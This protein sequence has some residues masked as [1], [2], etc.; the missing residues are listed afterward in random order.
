MKKSEIK[1]VI[2]DIGGVLLLGDKKMKYGHQNINVHAYLSKQFNMSLKEWF[3][4]IQIDY[5]KSIT[6]RIS[7]DN[8]LKKIS[9]QLNTNPKKLEKLLILAHK[10]FYKKNKELYDSAK[11]L[12]RKCLI[13]ILSDQTPFS[14]KA[15]LNKKFLS[16]FN[17]IILSCDV[18]MRKPDKEIYFLL[19]KRINKIEKVSFS[20]ILFIDNRQFNLEPAKKLG[21]QTLLFKSN[22]QL[23]KTSIWRNL[24]K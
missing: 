18:K 3:H 9:K 11:K 6:G 15:L 21:M 14:K 5:K 10:K 7:K 8:I 13:G 12:K 16:P 22:K 2:F 23:F 24:F 17:P 20:E 1:A 19:K 4:K